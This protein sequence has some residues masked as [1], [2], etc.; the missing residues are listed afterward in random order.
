[1]IEPNRI[2]HGDC[3]KILPQIA[4]GSV[5]MVLTDPP[6]NIANNLK[7]KRNNF[8]RLMG[9]GKDITNNFGEWDEMNDGEFR[10]FCEEW[11]V[12]AGKKIKDNGHFVSFFNKER[13]HYLFEPLR[14]QGFRYRNVLVWHKLNPTPQLLKANFCSATEFIVWMTKGDKIGTF[15][16]KEGYCHNIFESSICQGTERTEHPTQKN[17][18]VVYWLLKYLSNAGDLILDPFAG[19]GTTL[20]AAKNLGRRYL[21]IEKEEK[22]YNIAVD[23][24]GGTAEP[25]F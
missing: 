14:K 7:L 2:I 4:D 24:I 9:S 22:Y 20:V 15:N 1:M 5:D 6:Y 13:M 19:S 21:G 16:W 17:I 12:L 8:N 18:D 23:R 3:L 10:S 25:L 11:L